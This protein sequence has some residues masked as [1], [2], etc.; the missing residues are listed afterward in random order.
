MQ[1]HQVSRHCILKCFPSLIASQC[2]SAQIHQHCS[3]SDYND[4]CMLFLCLF[5]QSRLILGQ[6]EVKGANGWNW[7]SMRPYFLKQ[8]LHA[9]NPDDGVNLSAV[10]CCGTLQVFTGADLD[11]RTVVLTVYGKQAVSQPTKSLAPS[12]KLE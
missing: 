2:Y 7:E 8:E 10:R 9:P 3:P 5:Y 6:W 1:F 12:L 11:K 4:V